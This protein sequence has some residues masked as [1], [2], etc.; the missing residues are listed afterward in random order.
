MRSQFQT[1]LTTSGSYFKSLNNLSYLI[2]YLMKKLL[3]SIFITLIISGFPNP[4]QAQDEVD[5]EMLAFMIDF[6]EKLA[7]LLDDYSTNFSNTVGQIIPNA[8]TESVF[9]DFTSKVNL[10]E[11]IE[12]YFTRTSELGDFTYVGVFAETEDPNEAYEIYSG[13][14]FLVELG[15]YDCCE[16]ETIVMPE[17]EDAYLARTVF[18]PK[19]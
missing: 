15:T 17:K 14:S 16:L 3:T 6:T 7:T 9:T 10:P 19:V 1:D 8:D 5:T 12:S 4:V 18:V 11:T 13:V 2:L